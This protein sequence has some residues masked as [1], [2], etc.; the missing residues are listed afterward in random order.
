MVCWGGMWEAE[1]GEA[2]SFKAGV[3]ESGDNAC[4]TVRCI[5]RSNFYNLYIYIYITIFFSRREESVITS[6][7][8]ALPN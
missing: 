7:R 8:H 1:K 4:M 2:D 5:G 3:C 6:I